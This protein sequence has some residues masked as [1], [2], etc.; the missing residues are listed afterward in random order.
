MT[1]KD[2]IKEFTSLKGVGEAKA[3][4]LYSHGYDSMEKLRRA[5]VEDLTKIKGISK[6]NASDIIEQLHQKP[7]HKKEKKPEKKD[8]EE[9]TKPTETKKAVEE[10]EKTEDSDKKS[11]VQDEV[12]IVDETEQRYKPKI[13]PVVTDDLKRQLRIRKQLKKRTPEFLR[14]EWFRYKRIPRNWRAPDGYTSKM[15]RN[16]KYRPSKVRIGFK[17]PHDVRG[18]HP[19]GFSEVIIHTPAELDKLDPKTQAARIGATVGTKKRQEI[20]KKAQER[21]IRVLN[22]KV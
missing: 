15:R 19:S 5:S 6:K 12:E 11:S 1:K 7:E 21:N 8:T 10:K 9:K 4:L 20:A 22:M 3:E 17:G 14:E 18:L 13:K 16:F 2:V